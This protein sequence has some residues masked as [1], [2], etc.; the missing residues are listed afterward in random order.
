[1]SVNANDFVV[2]FDPTGSAVITGAQLAQL[3]NSAY[4]QVDKGMT[5]VTT[6]SGTVANPPDVTIEPK[7]KRYIWIRQSATSVSAYVWNEPNGAWESL[8][9][10]GIAEGSITGPKLAM[11]TVTDEKIHNLNAT[12]LFGSFPSGMGVITASTAATNDLTG[13]FG[14]PSINEDAITTSKIL[15]NTITSDKIQSATSITTGIDCTTKL[16]SAG[17]NNR[18]LNSKS[19]YTCEW[20]TPPKIFSSG[21][22]VTDTGNIGKVPRVL[23]EGPSDTGSWEMVPY[24]SV[25]IV[26]VMTKQALATGLSSA[27]PSGTLTAINA[28]NNTTPTFDTDSRPAGYNGVA[29][30]YP[31]DHTY[32]PVAPVSTIYISGSLHIGFNNAPAAGNYMIVV[33]LWNGATLLSTQTNLLAFSITGQS[34]RVVINAEVNNT[35]QEALNIKLCVQSQ[36]AGIAFGVNS[37]YVAG[38]TIKPAYKT[39][40]DAIVLDTNFAMTTGADNN[41]QA[42]TISGYSIT[43]YV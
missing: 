5:V 17:T 4:P 21:V 32:T 25:S 33:T 9:T 42:T 37:Y 15:N 16:R 28:G 2:G 13:T 26:N 31:F 29:I 39:T 7:W 6:D 43:E 11:D 1:M 27:S 19:D 36:V 18:V 41:Q 3:V 24:K 35:T 22:V 40:P 23:T 14:S 34:Y 10:A 20:I 38:N 12:K 8:N 30:Y